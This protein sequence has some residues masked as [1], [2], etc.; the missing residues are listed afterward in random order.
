MSP[1]INT[2]YFKLMKTLSANNKK[3]WEV[4]TLKLRDQNAERILLGNGKVSSSIINN[5][6]Q[7]GESKI[8]GGKNNFGL[9]LFKSFCANQMN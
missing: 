3:K 1:D 5:L 7:E 6:K 2:E 8:E 9:N 4:V